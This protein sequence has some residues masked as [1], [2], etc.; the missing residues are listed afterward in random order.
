VA[1]D[2][3]VEAA[4][5]GLVVEPELGDVEQEQGRCGEVEATSGSDAVEAQAQVGRRVLRSEEQ[6]GAWVGRSEAAERRRAGSD[7]EREL[8]GDPGLE[9]LCRVP[10]YTA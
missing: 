3:A 1:R 4:Q 2:G 9:R 6:D 10:D 8:G 7:R 5:M